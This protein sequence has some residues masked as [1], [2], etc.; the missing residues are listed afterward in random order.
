MDLNALTYEQVKGSFETACELCERMHSVE[1]IWKG[2]IRA[3]ERHGYFGKTDDE[4]FH[5][6][7]DFMRRFHKERLLENC[8]RTTRLVEHVKKKRVVGASAEVCN[9]K[10]KKSL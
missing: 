1:L 3:G 9:I 7:L 4:L 2:T 10:R 6:R 8:R 5:W